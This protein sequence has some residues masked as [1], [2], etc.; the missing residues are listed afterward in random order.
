MFART[1]GGLA[2]GEVRLNSPA[3]QRI[4]SN[5][6]DPSVGSAIDP[7]TGGGDACARVPAGTAPG[8]ANYTLPVRGRGFTLGRLPHDAGH[9]R[10]LRQPGPDPDRRPALGHRPR[11]QADPDRP[12]LLPAG[13]RQ[14]HLALHPGAWRFEPG[15]TVKLELLGN[16]Q[17]F[18]RPP[19]SNFE[20]SVRELLLKLPVRARPNCKLIR[21]VKLLRPRRASWHRAG[22]RGRRANAAASG[23]PAEAVEGWA[24]QGSNL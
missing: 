23:A 12:Q 21:P 18:G 11:R 16:D 8:T 7:V 13:G 22:S 19:T 2:R 17:P 9:D 3:E 6:G 24:V 20:L 10:R 4:A 1:Y 5:G 14:E 15:H